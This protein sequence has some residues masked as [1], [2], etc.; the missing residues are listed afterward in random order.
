VLESQS[1]TKSRPI[2]FDLA[3]L[4]AKVPPGVALE[5]RLLGPLEVLEEERT[6]ALAGEKPRALLIALALRAGEVVSVD[7]LCEALWEGSP[8]Q[9]AAATLQ[10]HV[11]KLRKTLG[12]DAIVT[13]P[14][15][16]R[17]ALASEA[18]DARRFERRLVAGRAA[19]RA[20]DAER[21]ARLLSQALALWRGEVLADVAYA[22]FAQAERRRLEE[23]LLEA[24][25]ERIEADLACGRAA[26]L[27][28][29]LEALASEHPLRE[30]LRGQLL[31][32]LYRSGRQAEALN[33]YQEARRLFLEELGIDPS[34]E[35]QELHR[36][37]LNQDRELVAETPAGERLRLPAAP[38]PLVGR[39]G[40]L[41]KVTAFLVAAEPRLVTL[42]GPGG[43]GKTRLALELAHWAD[44]ELPGGARFLSLAPLRDTEL[45]L[46]QIASA[47][48]IRE[49]GRRPL[50]TELAERLA[51]PTLL[52][53]DNFEQLVEAAEAVAALASAAPA[54][55]VLVTSRERLRVRGEREVSLAPLEPHEGVELFLTRAE[56]A[57]IAL[58]RSSLVEELCVRLDQLPLALELAAARTKALS[59]EQL[60]ARLSRGLDIL[61]GGRD[62]D[63]RQQTLRATIEWSYD[64]LSEE[65]QRLFRALSVF[66]GGC[67]L[68][69]A[70]EVADADLD[71]LQSL[72][73][74]SLVRFS[75]GRFWMLET[76]REYAVERLAAEGE[77]EEA[78]GRHA[79]WIAAMTGRF[80]PDLLGRE[81]RDALSR[82]DDEIENLRAAM[83]WWEHSADPNASTQFMLDANEYMWR[84]DHGREMIPRFQ[85]LLGVELPRELRLPLLR[86]LGA[87][88]ARHGR[89]EQGIERL[90]EAVSI[91]EELDHPGELARMRYGL[92]SALTEIGRIEEAVALF[93]AALEGY[94]SAGSPRGFAVSQWALADIYADDDPARALRL[95]DGALA[96]HR[97]SDDALG[98]AWIQSLRAQL[99]WTLG[100]EREAF[101]SLLESLDTYVTVGVLAGAA[102]ALAAFVKLF[103]ASEPSVAAAA[104]SALDGEVGD[105]LSVRDRR[106]LAA[107]TAEIGI[108]PLDRNVDPLEVL[109]E[110]R[111]VV[112]STRNTAA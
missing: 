74:K 16:Y 25:E 41:A 83:E 2:W 60:L 11:A 109:R 107:S 3:D 89:V 90:R 34:P 17:L 68:E 33:A 35:L 105:Q 72:V 22:A 47:C 9:T 87:A 55:R 61:R 6:L 110:A 77:Q 18:I 5:V 10:M 12:R 93:E 81:Q 19:L 94:A 64:L 31:I 63:P 100:S 45:L 52:V 102:E 82:L 70:E 8:P 32:A 71:T 84:R 23:L 59:P 96:F 14:A 46:P 97:E 99:Q 111:E 62:A 86:A 65:E 44:A 1:P 43:V 21:A 75:G 104:L 58:E 36:R 29:E 85:R 49:R 101:E 15:G 30:R 50:V 78:T 106:R 73:E 108:S 26:E 103:A 42:T 98:V 112:A 7:Q 39:K 91:A 88:L 28:P 51:E 40:E 92:A 95:L 37:I 67:T 69:A 57:G 27:V 4:G 56:D 66:V 76:I 48:G 54:L 53:L 80:V 20:G 38:T 79:A 24:R 13:D